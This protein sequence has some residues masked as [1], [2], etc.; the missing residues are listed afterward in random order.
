MKIIYRGLHPKVCINQ[1]EN[2]TKVF[3][4]YMIIEQDIFAENLDFLQIKH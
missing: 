1:T 4:E 3:I 2:V